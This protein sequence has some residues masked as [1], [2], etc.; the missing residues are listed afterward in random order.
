M[1]LMRV[2]RKSRQKYKYTKSAYF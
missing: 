2:R 1:Q